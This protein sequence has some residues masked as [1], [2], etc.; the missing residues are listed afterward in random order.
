MTSGKTQNKA[1]HQ[2]DSRAATFNRS[3]NWI[4]DQKLINSH[5]KAA[6]KPHGKG[7]EFCCGT[8]IIASGLAKAGWNMI[9]VDISTEMLKHAE[10]SLQKIQGNIEN[11][12]FKDNQFDL[13]VMRQ[14]LFFLNSQKALNEVKRN[15]KKSGKFILSQTVPF[16]QGD[17]PWLKKIHLFKQTQLRKFYTSSELKKELQKAGFKIVKTEYLSVRE[18]I[19]N[20]MNNAPELTKQKRQEICNMVVHCPDEYRQ[21]RNVEVINGEIFENWN[22]VVITAKLQ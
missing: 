18:S 13:V 12:P 10:A 14:A 20:W 9:G 7:L 15:L 2:F 19:S 3:A 22:W 4:T 5:V 1:I 16:S 8:G 21:I 17:S 6:G 11:L